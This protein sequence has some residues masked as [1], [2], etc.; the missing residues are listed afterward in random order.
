MTLRNMMGIFL[1][2]AI[3]CW[4]LGSARTGSAQDQ[5][6]ADLEKRG[7]MALETGNYPAALELFSEG[8]SRAAD[9]ETKARLDF[10]QAVALQQ[11]VSNSE[12][13]NPEEQ[14]RQAARLYQSY[15]TVHPESAAAANNL[16][17]IYEQMGDEVLQSPKPERARRYFKSAAKN[18]Q[19]AVAAADS[20]AG[21]YL[22]N[23]A[24]LLEKAGEWKRAKE[25]YARLV[26][27]H[28]LSP[29]LLQSITDSYARH[30]LGELAEFTWNLLDAGYV[31]Q[32][33][34]ISINAIRNS[35]NESDEGRIE[36]LTV[37]CAG[38]A[39]G[40]DDYRG[41][42][43]S[44][45][46]VQMQALVQD[47]FLG[48]GAA[49]VV[50][51]YQAQRFDRSEYQWWGQRGLPRKDPARGLWPADGFRALI[52]SLGSRAKRMG[53]L[54]L[55]EQYFRLAADL[56]EREIDPVAVRA[57]VQMYAEE[58]A[59]KRIDRL[60][61]EYKVRLFKGKGAAYRESRVERIFQYHQTLGELYALI[62]RWGDSSKV[63]SAIFQLEHAREKSIMLENNSSKALPEKYQFTPQMV[64]IL[65]SG[66]EK[67][68]QTGKGT[69]LRIDQAERYQKAGDTKATQRVL[70]PVKAVEVPSSLQS[71]YQNLRVSPEIRKPVR[72]LDLQRAA[73]KEKEG[74]GQ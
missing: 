49:E 37:V 24:E 58:N 25:M 41:F 51:L 18:Y 40:T 63:D 3:G 66:Y 15:L 36:L 74:S 56:Q 43:E 30:G 53:K 64:D 16:A 62:E 61:S 73:V 33:V 45:T 21:L 27:D 39:E 20:R 4:A 72:N 47:R 52:R 28:P 67:T 65:S 23:Y 13:D 48:E 22:K 6:A 69:E 7:R 46:G 59:Y 68:G 32:S 31:R 44:G 12:T 35:R 55:A 70:A 9:P 34:D 54:H 42:L 17:K 19:K 14:L 57:L 8:S 71:R 2:L 11:M 5:V 1:T 10:R 29:A 38:L 26:Q 60:L 50:R